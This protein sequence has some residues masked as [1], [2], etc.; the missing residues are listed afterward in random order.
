M[1]PFSALN[2]WEEAVERWQDSL[3]AKARPRDPVELVEALLRE[4]DARAV[5]CSQSRVVVPNAYE[6][7]LSREVHRQLC[8]YADRI[9]PLLTDALLRHG[10][11]RGYEWAGPLTVRLCRSTL[12]AGARYRVTSTPMRHISADAFPAP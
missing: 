7:E 9:G 3:L 1:S 8:R 10:E 2:R 5:V 6:V 12:P 11:A 4:C